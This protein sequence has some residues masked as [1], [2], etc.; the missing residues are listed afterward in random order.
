MRHSHYASNHAHSHSHWA[1]PVDASEP[2]ASTPIVTDPSDE[3]GSQPVVT[4][5]VTTPTTSTPVV[6]DTPSPVATP[7]ITTPVAA[8]SGEAISLTRHDGPV[9]AH[10]GEV[11]K[12][13]DIY[14]DSG[15]ALTIEANN[16]TVEDVRIHYNGA[17]GAAEGMG[18]LVTGAND[19]IKNVEIFNAGA[20][21]AGAELN[22]EHYGI[23]A[24]GA[25]SL[26]VSGATIHDAS[27]GI[28]VLNSPGTT[29][30]GI[31]GYDMRGPMPRG[32]L[33]QFDKSDNSTL[34]NF[35][36]HNDPKIAFTEDNI[37]VYESNNVTVSNGVIDGNNSASGQGVIFEN[38]NNGLASHI[39]AIHMGNGAFA[40]YGSNN[41]FDFTRSF[42]NIATDQGRGE[43]P[44]SN[45]LIWGLSDTTVVTHSSYQNPAN[46]ANI[47]YGGGYEDEAHQGTIDVT[48]V[49]GQTPMAHLT[50]DFL[51]A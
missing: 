27:T 13:L 34:T 1:S 3:G 10:D 29:L 4:A 23:Q 17:G 28:Y 42:D 2:V 22:A 46:P 24:V 19:T 15:T 16:V 21:A 50:N 45:A 31:E 40:D 18:I 48:Q 7:V 44:L 14:V 49:T 20:P 25:Q 11:L 35:Y 8:T 32:Q 30:E 26:N 5:P 51:W 6:V 47:I 37:S 33:V 9:V 12:N 36:V 43:L 39:D 38:S 41:T